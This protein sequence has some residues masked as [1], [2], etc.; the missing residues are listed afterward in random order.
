MIKTEKIG[1]RDVHFDEISRKWIYSDTGLPMTYENRINNDLYRI[2]KMLTATKANDVDRLNAL[3]DELVGIVDGLEEE[4]RRPEPDEKTFTVERDG[5]IC[6]FLATSWR[7]SGRYLQFYR[8]EE[9]VAEFE[10]NA[11]D[12]KEFDGVT[13]VLIYH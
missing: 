5:E 11:F 4:I 7:T 8:K 1:E 13:E 9:K 6:N 10:F 12:M 2:G 3:A